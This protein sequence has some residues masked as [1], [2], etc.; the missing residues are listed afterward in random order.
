[1]NLT[2]LFDTQDVL[3]TRIIEER[4]LQG[5]FLLN[6][7]IDAFRVELHE[8]ENEVRHFKFWSNK[9]MDR[10]RSLE[11]YVD[12]LHFLLSI[13][14]F[15]DERSPWIVTVKCES[16]PKQFRSL[17][18]LSGMMYDDNYYSQLFAEYLGLGE[19]LGFTWEQIEEA[20]MDKNEVNHARQDNN[21]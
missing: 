4:G 15:L 17:A 20:Y 12:G 5:K 1:M 18:K 6:E 14:N 2:K 21:Y 9:K 3:D 13:G 10:E 16:I 7:R 8:L 11:E 19:M